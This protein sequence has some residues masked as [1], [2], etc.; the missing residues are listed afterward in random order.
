[1]SPLIRQNP[2]VALGDDSPA[3]GCPH[4]L[5]LLKDRPPAGAAAPLELVR[6]SKR[7]VAARS[8]RLIWIPL[9]GADDHGTQREEMCLHSPDRIPR[10]T[11][12]SR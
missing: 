11:F 5:E 7:I 1:M 3:V 2:G 9:S 6:F 12:R 4:P 10:D 8:M